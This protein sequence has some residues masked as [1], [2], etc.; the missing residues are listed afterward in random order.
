MDFQELFGRL[1]FFSAL[2]LICSGFICH[3]IMNIEEKRGFPFSKEFWS[4]FKIGV[5]V[6]CGAF[7]IGANVWII[8]SIIEWWR[9]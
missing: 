6:L 3:F 4:E 2:G 8:I 5:W 7:S 1:A 9:E